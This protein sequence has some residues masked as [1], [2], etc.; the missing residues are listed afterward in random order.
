[1]ASFTTQ[2]FAWEFSLKGEYE[3]RFRYIGRS[4]DA[5]LFGNQLSISEVGFA[6]QN[7]YG[8]LDWASG[9]AEPLLVPPYTALPTTS[10]VPATRTGTLAGV[11]STAA[12]AGERIIRGGFSTFGSDMLLNDSRLTLRPELRVNA[13]IRVSGVYTVGGLGNKYA[14]HSQPLVPD[15]F[16]LLGAVPAANPLSPQSP[17]NSGVGVPPFE[18]YYRHQ[19]SD[20]AYDTAAIGS[21]EQFRATIQTPWT[22][23]SIG[24]KDFPFG[25]GAT[26]SKGL[27]S[28]TF[29]MVTPY[30]PFRMLWG[31]WLARN[32]TNDG[33]GTEPDGARKPSFFQGLLATYEAG[34]VSAGC[35]YILRQ[36]HAQGW[37]NPNYGFF[38]GAPPAANTLASLQAFDQTLQFWMA[39]IRYNNGRF[40]FN[41]EYAAFDL[42]QHFVPATAATVAGSTMGTTLV[43]GRTPTYGEGYHWFTELGAV[44]Q[45]LRVTAMN[46]VSSGPVLN[47]ENPTKVYMAYPID[48]QAMEP[49]EFLMFNTY[50]GGND[51]FSGLLLPAD[52]HGMMGDAFCFAGR[53][54]YA[55][56]A[57]LNV[58]TSYIWSHRLEKQGFLF[59]GKNSFGGA[60]SSATITAF[61]AAAGRQAS[62]TFIGGG[63]NFLGGHAPTTTATFGYP[64]NGFIGWEVN[65]GADWKL[66]EGMTSCIRYSYWQPGDWFKEAYQAHVLAALGTG[67]TDTGVLTSRVAIQAV[68]VSLSIDF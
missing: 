36:H 40:F 42:D 37:T 44:W 15:A 61:A 68:N 33:W 3:Y 55:V 43:P 67:V 27:R 16:A 5:D 56:A 47:Y 35:G 34:D 8:H 51:T 28:E 31:I 6:G 11:N 2:S 65:A 59:G 64:S 48:Y 45:S 14:Q 9:L 1:M 60:G 54:D 53:L 52:G 38:T 46:A 4:G 13:A 24:V 17:F 7:I 63:S 39:F 22:I 41:A 29:L 23:F 18:R 57:N 58:W 32:A 66:L 12:K 49:Y 26:L 50:G 62:P 20:N 21:W 25:L 30:G 10:T 19:T